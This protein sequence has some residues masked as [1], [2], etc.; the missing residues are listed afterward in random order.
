MYI[1]D[2]IERGEQRCGDW[3]F[4]NVRNGIATCDCGKEFRLEDGEALSADPYAI[5]VCGECFDKA[6][7][8]R[9]GDK[10]D[11]T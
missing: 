10:W 5:P 6:I 8:E 4:D 9:Y 11:Q 3:Y 1:P 2:P 7:R